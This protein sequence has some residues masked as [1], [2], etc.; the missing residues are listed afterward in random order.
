MKIDILCTDGSPIGVIPADIYGTNGRVGVGGSELALLTL[1]QAWT[2]RGD[3]V[4]LYNNPKGPVEEFPQLPVERFDKEQDRDILI[5]FRTP[6]YAVQG[7]KGK[8]VWWSC[9]QYTSADFKLFAPEVDEIVTI[10]QFHAEYFKEKY[11]I[12]RTTI[13]DIPVR[14]WEYGQQIERVKNQVIFCSVP[15]RGLKEMGEVW[16]CINEQMPE[17]SLIITSDYRLWGVSAAMNEQYMFQFVNKN[18]RV[19]GAVLRKE[20]IEYQLSSDLMVY[21]CT[22]DELFCI[23]V[24]ECSVAGA[25]PIT[26]STGALATT[27]MG[28]V[29]PGNPLDLGWQRALAG[30]VVDILNDPKRLENLR[31]MLMIEAR[32]RF[33]ISKIL[34]QWDKVFN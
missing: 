16:R 15:D 27:N 25:Y 34:K 12:N 32:E 7:A 13:I 9:D 33:N 1:C 18:A 29:L 30:Q 22:Y 21:P 19:L 20:L 17:A 31:S 14:T 4:V 26:S 24:A 5:V 8:K 6:N 3:D 23:S 2:K 28:Y 10:S 11:G